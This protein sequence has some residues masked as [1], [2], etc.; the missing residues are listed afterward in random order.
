[1]LLHYNRVGEI[2][3]VRRSDR[4]VYSPKHPIFVA[5]ESTPEN[6]VA[7]VAED[8]SVESVVL[9]PES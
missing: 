8:P 5:E 6:V 7:L 1:M 2:I 4:F 9:T 3:P